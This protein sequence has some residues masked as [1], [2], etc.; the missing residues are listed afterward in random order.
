MPYRKKIATLSSQLIMPAVLLCTASCSGDLVIPRYSSVE[1]TPF[2]IGI[3]ALGVLIG[4][5][6]Y[7]L[8]LALTTREPMF[9]YFSVMMVLLSILQTFSTYDRFFFR[10]TYNRV[11]VL[12]HTLFITFLLF[13][14]DFYRVR[15]HRTALSAWNRISIII[16]AAYTGLFLL[17]KAL[18]PGATGLH[19]ALNFTRELF[20]FYTNILFLANC[21]IAMQWM[22][23]EALIILIA[24]IPPA[25]L[26][27]LNAMNI[28][29]FMARFE[30]FTRIMMQYNQPVGLSLQ[31]IL[32]S[33]AMGNRYNRIKAERLRS[34][35]ERDRLKRLDREK[36]EY[37]MDVSHELR[38]PLTIILGLTRQLQQ[39]RLGDSI[40]KNKKTFDALERNGLR[41][42]KQLNAMLRMEQ[43][44]AEDSGRVTVA[45]QLRL[46]KDEF[47]PIA[48][49]KGISLSFEI[50]GSVEGVSL[51]VSP[52]D[53]DS[54]VLNLLSNAVKYTPK[55]GR[56]LVTVEGPSARGLKIKVEDTG[57]GIPGDYHKAIFDRFRRYEWMKARGSGL[58]LPV[59]KSIMESRGGSVDVESRV[60]E[61]SCFTL[62]FPPE[63]ISRSGPGES[64]GT[65]FTDIDLYTAEFS[66]DGA[67]VHPEPSGKG[68]LIMLVED[69]E[70]M[71]MYISS[72]LEEDFRL[73]T[74]RNGKEALERLHHHRVDMIISDVMMDEM[75]GH[76]FFREYRDRY[77]NST[78]P[79]L[80]L[81]ARDSFEEKLR[82]LRGGAV[83]Y[84]T[85]P[86]HPRELVT[87][88]TS[89]I[90]RDRHVTVSHIS[91]VRREIDRVLTGMER[92]PGAD[93][94][95]AFSPEEARHTY[96]LSERETDVLRCILT[97]CSDK[98]IARELNL[99][100]RTVANHNRRLYKKLDVASRV[101]VLAKMTKGED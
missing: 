37:Y 32:L 20:V 97:G 100:P 64:T 44:G 9:I 5:F 10:L 6:F 82:S 43:P 76:T 34:G 98:E 16:I 60:G 22:K 72:I 49:E 24:F 70:D 78:V 50:D 74:A 54:A 52:E 46:Y 63:I 91:R 23:T 77:K 73:I 35:D 36:S 59:V 51:R 33:L 40:R 26:T 7:N 39:G 65:G 86:F 48:G 69:N 21:I 29:P 15:Q 90:E 71:L 75:D 84:I 95:P 93:R 27:S 42:L 61:G 62:I 92:G 57:S 85:K 58:G 45:R 67:G 13:F 96:G 19:G 101:E 89:T 8:F 4:L 28:F 68:P 30:G 55:G 47:A 66:S 80:F 31:A 83:H 88:V 56:V 79:F 2:I 25:F 41:L 18:L 99:S 87:L 14:E 11:T 12:T 38:T 1:S 3:L 17:L 81:T 94:I 53:F